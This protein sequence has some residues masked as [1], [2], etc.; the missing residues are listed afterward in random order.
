MLTADKLGVDAARALQVVAEG[1]DDPFA[2]AQV[3]R[4]AYQQAT[5]LLQRLAGLKGTAL[6]RGLQVGDDATW[7][8]FAALIDGYSEDDDALA[9]Y[10][11]ASRQLLDPVFPAG[12]LATADGHGLLPVNIGTMSALHGMVAQTVVFAGMIDG[13]NPVMNAISDMV[14]PNT[15]DRQLIRSRRELY[16]AMSAAT[17]ELVFSYFSKEEC[18]VAMKLKMDIRRIT[19]ERGGRVAHLRPSLF[20]EE[21]GA[22]LP[23]AA[24]LDGDV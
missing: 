10:E 3:L 4:E 13:F 17:D 16:C 2:L 7:N 21:M 8:D 20:L 23:E 14:A 6:V 11:R 1:D 9:L 22:V 24:G 19:A 15:R 12:R 5:K 18:E